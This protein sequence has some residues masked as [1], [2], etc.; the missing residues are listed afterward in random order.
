MTN[1]M[2]RDG[3]DIDQVGYYN[4]LTKDLFFEK[5]K[6]IKWLQNGAQPTET[7]KNLLI[8]SNLIKN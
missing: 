3:K 5:G 8:K 6:I 7:V 4:P 1:N 2:K